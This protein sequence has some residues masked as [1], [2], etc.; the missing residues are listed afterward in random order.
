MNIKI[1]SHV[2]ADLSTI[3]NLLNEANRG[4]YEFIPFTEERLQEWLIEG[5]LR[6]LIAEEDDQ[7]LGTSAYH[8]GYWGEEIEWLI[9][10]PL[11]NRRF[12]EKIL[13]AE[14][15][16]L[17]KSGKVFT[18]VDEGSSR[19]ADWIDLGY[20]PEGGLYHL[21]T[22]LAD[23][24]PMPKVDENVI[25]R[26]LKP[27]EEK[28]FVQI[29]NAGF[30]WERLKIGTI[31]EWKSE[32]STFSEDWIHVAEVDNRIVSTV[33][34]K[35]DLRHNEYFGTNRGY[36]GP[37]TT[38]PEFRRKNLASA[39]T[40][41]AMN[42]LYEKGVRTVALYTS[43]QNTASTMLLQKLNFTVGHHWKFMRKTFS[44]DVNPPKL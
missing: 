1:R 20:K 11:E 4:G 31:K 8:D 23:L 40:C 7:F 42:F 33:V 41:R 10:P 28:D 5:K 43:E 2:N 14:A 30:G 21:T 16:R 29:V 36:L 27:D 3:V 38:L 22:K 13:I 44:N 24:V 35:M 15:E 18:V 19:I 37:A 32:S 12:I 39:L 9:V 34:A 17:V 25:L 26:S 6:I